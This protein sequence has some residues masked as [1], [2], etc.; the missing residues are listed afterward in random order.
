MSEIFKI[1][2]YIK[3]IDE[4]K[5][6]STQMCEVFSYDDYYIK[7]LMKKASASINNKQDFNALVFAN[8]ALELILNKGKIDADLSL[9][10]IVYLNSGNFDL[11]ITCIMKTLSNRSNLSSAF[12]LFLISVFNIKNK[13]KASNFFKNYLATYKDGSL[14]QYADIIQHLQKDLDTALLSNLN[15]NNL[16]REFKRNANAGNAD[17]AKKQ[18]SILWELDKSDIFINYWYHNYTDG[19]FINSIYDIPYTAVLSRCNEIISAVNSN[20]HLEYLMTGRGADC[21]INFTLKNFDF[22]TSTYLINK[23]LDV[24]NASENNML[25]RVLFSLENYLFSD[26]E[27]MKKLEIFLLYVQNNLKVCKSIFNFRYRDVLVTVS[28]FTSFANCN[29]EY[30][31]MI[32]KVI[33]TLVIRGFTNID[34]FDILSKLSLP[35]YNLEFNNFKDDVT[36]YSYLIIYLFYKKENV[37]MP[38]EYEFVETVLK[39][40]GLDITDIV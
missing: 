7:D 34:L 5:K 28:I 13:Q 32:S 26:A 6:T 39:L 31:K 27:D 19:A 15:I 9:H 1:G 24:I 3:S 35:N 21:L 12:L 8:K 40:K 23:Y 14:A 10:S 37:N 16:K 29:K 17:V 33:N 30:G 38:N 2:D 20:E 11:A 22:K 4:C 25:A 36:F 18:L